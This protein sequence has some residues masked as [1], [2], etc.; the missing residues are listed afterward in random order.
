MFYFFCLRF[1]SFF[2]KRLFSIEYRGIENIP[3]EGRLI[4]CCNHKS[5]FDPLFLA[6][7]FKRQIRYMAKS[8][9][10]E[11]HGAVIRWVLYRLGAF[12][13][14]RD[15]GDAGSVRRAVQILNQEGLLGIFPQGKC[16][17]DDTPFQPKA[18]V[19]MIAGLSKAPVLPAS[20]YCD[21][22]IKPFK[23]ITVRYG[24]PIFPDE[25][26]IREKSTASIRSAALVIAEKINQ[27]LEEKY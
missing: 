22:I 7:P 4:V 27:M 12:P 24:K 21:G 26:D 2:A 16:V 6:M 9:L 25:L 13:V 20:I 3:E 8:E 19:A 1:L 5:V 15:S 10:F 18:G 23:R 14:K 11:E 17:F